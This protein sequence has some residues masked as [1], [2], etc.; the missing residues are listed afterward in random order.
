[1]VASY[2]RAENAPWSRRL[3]A[4]LASPDGRPA[5]VVRRRAA[6]HDFYSDELADAAFL[7]REP[8]SFAVFGKPGV[9][10]DELAAALSA[11]WGCVH[12]SVA[13]GLAAGRASDTVMSALRRGSAVNVVAASAATPLAG[14]LGLDTAEVRTRGYV[15]SG[16]PRYAGV[17]TPG[18]SA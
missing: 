16:F 4:D 2:G 3:D 17:C 14:L 1:M 18:F 15:L 10:D 6:V 13:I 11:H 8:V 9:P 5:V 12:V 7:E